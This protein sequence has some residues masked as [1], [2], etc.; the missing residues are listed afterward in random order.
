VNRAIFAMKVCSCRGV[1]RWPRRSRR[2][3]EIGVPD[4][5]IGNLLTRGLEHQPP[6]GGNAA[7]ALFPGVRHGRA[8][9][10]PALITKSH[11]FEEEIRFLTVEEVLL[12]EPANGIKS[13]SA[14]EETARI[15]K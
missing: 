12:V 9:Y 11:Q 2:S 10:Q 15:E 3:S 14:N 13:T 7:Q 6:E 1:L 5:G 8:G 4:H